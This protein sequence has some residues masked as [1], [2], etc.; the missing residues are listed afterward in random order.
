MQYFKYQYILS[1]CISRS[2]FVKILYLSNIIKL[3]ISRKLLTVTI[4]QIIVVQT[5]I[6]N[7]NIKIS[8]ILI[9]IGV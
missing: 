7:P 9:I 3:L 5:S 8:I 1:I 6:F 2:S 4:I